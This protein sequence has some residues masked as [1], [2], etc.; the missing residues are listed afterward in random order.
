M[1]EGLFSGEEDD[2]ANDECPEEMHEIKQIVIFCFKACP[3]NGG[4][5]QSVPTKTAALG[6]NS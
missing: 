6:R 5:A 3:G 1:K 4:H 2:I